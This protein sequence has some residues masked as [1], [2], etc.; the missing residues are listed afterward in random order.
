[1]NEN[2][3]TTPDMDTVYE[4]L[5]E[6]YEIAENDIVIHTNLELFQD[7]NNKNWKKYQL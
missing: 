2:K 4:S 6:V 3:P 7:L 5:R 1:M